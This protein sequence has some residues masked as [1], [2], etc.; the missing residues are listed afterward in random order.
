MCIRTFK[1]TFDVMNRIIY[2]FYDDD[3][4]WKHVNKY[5]FLSQIWTFISKTT[6]ISPIKFMLQSVYL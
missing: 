5:D 6:W 4:M 1:V 2:A 3:L